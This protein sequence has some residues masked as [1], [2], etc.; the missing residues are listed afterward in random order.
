MRTTASLDFSAEIVNNRSSS[1]G[2]DHYL[3]WMD[4]NLNCKTAPHRGCE[5]ISLASLFRLRLPCGSGN[6]G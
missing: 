3:V 6:G 2:R 4:T 1:T 5:W